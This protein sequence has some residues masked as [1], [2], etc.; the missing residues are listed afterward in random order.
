VRVRGAGGSRV[1]I[2]GVV[3]YRPGDRPHLSCQLRACR[4]KGE[5]KGF[6]WTDY[7]DLIVSRPITTCRPR[8]CGAGDGLVRIVKRKLKK[9]QCRPR[10]I[11]G[12]LAGTGLTIEP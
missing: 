12:C 2:A 6:T 8:W 1:G 11:G 9:I 7:R 3:C 4:R 5:A 10:L